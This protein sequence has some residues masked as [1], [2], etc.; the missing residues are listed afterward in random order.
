MTKYKKSL[1]ITIF[2]LSFVM[3]AIV[4]YFKTTNS[5]VANIGNNELF[6]EETW[7]DFSSLSQEDE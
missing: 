3:I 5:P 2:I 7:I 6:L 1:T 4:F